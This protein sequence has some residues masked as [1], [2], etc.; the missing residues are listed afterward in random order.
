MLD[1]TAINHIGIA[2]RSIEAQREFYEHVLGATFEG[3]HELPTQHVRV[4][5]FVIGPPGHEVRLELVEATSPNAAVAKFIEQHGE[6]LHHVAY[7]VDSL[8]KGL[9]TLTAEGVQLMDLS[10]RDGVHH[11]R[12]IAYLHPDS[13]HG[14]LTELCEPSLDPRKRES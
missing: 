3:I 6:G 8:D 7:T 14:V 11:N 10:P 5:F 12:R 9:A 2:V 13:S 4:G 1:I